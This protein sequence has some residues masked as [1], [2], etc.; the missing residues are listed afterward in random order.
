MCRRAAGSPGGSRVRQ[1]DPRARA[2]GGDE[3][4]PSFAGA[5]RISENHP[6]RRGGG[7]GQFPE[8]LHR[9][10]RPCRSLPP[11]RTDHGV[12]YRRRPGRGR[13]RRGD[14]HRP[15][16]ATLAVQQGKFVERVFYC[17]RKTAGCKTQDSRIA[18][19]L[20][21]YIRRVEVYA[22]DDG[23]RTTARTCLLQSLRHPGPDAR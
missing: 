19:S 14:G 9:S 2:D 10:R 6:G 1:A 11:L 3:P 8:T 15:R 12:G 17:E 21:S 23:Q 20:E 5:G 18:L 22:T 16:G 13:S 4:L 7:G